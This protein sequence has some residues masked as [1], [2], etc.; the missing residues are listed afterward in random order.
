MWESGQST[1]NPYRNTA[2]D[3]SPR[4]KE[5]SIDSEEEARL[6]AQERYRKWKEGIF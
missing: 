2:K 1:K 4:R 5:A 3:I 6:A